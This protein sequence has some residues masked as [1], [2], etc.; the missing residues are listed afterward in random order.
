MTCN[1]ASAIRKNPELL[2]GDFKNSIPTQR[3]PAATQW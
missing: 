1:V 3:F 2:E